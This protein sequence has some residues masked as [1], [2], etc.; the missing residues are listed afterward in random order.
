[1]NKKI[2]Y[3]IPCYNSA[4]FI[5]KTVD[6]LI[7]TIKKD[8]PE[9]NSEIIL[10]ND[11][12]KD[13]TFKK[14]KEIANTNANVIAVDLSRNFGQ[15]NAI[16]AGLKF[17]TG[18]IILAMDDD[19]QTAPSEIKKIISGL[20][21]DTDVVYAKYKHKKHN[22]FRNL[23]SRLN[24][25]MAVKLINKPKDLYVSSFFAMKKFVKDE[26]ITYTNPYP[27]II[28]LVLRSTNKIKNV[29]V[30]HNKRKVG[31]SNYTLKKLVGLLMNG[32]TNFSVTP[33][34]IALIFSII[35]GIAAII[36]AIIFIINKF[37]NP[38]V[39]LGWTSTIIVN[40]LIGASISFLLG[41]VGEYVGRIYMAINNNPQ[42]VI[43]EV[44]NE[45]K[46]RK[47]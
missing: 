2:S 45:K 8:L 24:D 4:L 46:E 44:I 35:F 37:I 16:M 28:G 6:D 3:V 43:R 36:L 9:Y 18:D 21:E 12:S 22:I 17:T 26:I 41:L 13:N 1:M 27:Y 47:N 19:G 30:T 10:V 31:K 34:R 29:T 23:G 20:D 11:A 5:E 25:F 38:N 7:N 33:L 15:H 14:I 40:L 42:Y 39:P 32:F